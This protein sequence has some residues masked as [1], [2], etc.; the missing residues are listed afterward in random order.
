MIQIHYP[1]KTNLKLFGPPQIVILSPLFAASHINSNF[2]G[3]KTDIQCKEKQL[4]CR[5]R[6]QLLQHLRSAGKCFKCDVASRRVNMNIA[7]TQNAHNGVLAV[8][9]PTERKVFFFVS[10]VFSLFFFFF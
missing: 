4:S 9:N 10:A 2:Q 1:N 3:K 5:L 7:G 6:R 8:M